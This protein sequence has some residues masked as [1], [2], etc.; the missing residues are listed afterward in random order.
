MSDPSIRYRRASIE[1][2]EAVCA[3]GNVV[4]AAHHDAW[5]Q[6]FAAP[7]ASGR[8]AAHW[9]AS[10]QHEDFVCFVAEHDGGLAGFVTVK[11]ADERS[12]LR[13]PMRYAEIGSVCVDEGLRGRGIGRRLM[14]LVEDWARMRGAADL[15]LVVWL[16]NEGAR[17]LYEELGY[18]PRSL[19]MGKPL[20]PA[21]P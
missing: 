15:R 16:F 3:L 2:L 7:G 9:A 6:L 21:A 20:D 12:T 11:V 13:P 17:R 4:N 14:G 8:D 10:L 18:V 1:D 19:A 5:P